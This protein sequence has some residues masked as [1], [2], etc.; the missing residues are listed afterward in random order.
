MQTHLY[1]ISRI[2]ASSHSIS[3]GQRKTFIEDKTRA[4]ACVVHGCHYFASKTRPEVNFIP[5]GQRGM[6]PLS[7]G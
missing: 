4:F 7:R 2:Y 1:F 3:G 6:C 5:P